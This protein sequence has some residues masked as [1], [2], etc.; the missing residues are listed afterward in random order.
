MKLVIF[1]CLCLSGISQSALAQNGK[2]YSDIQRYSLTFKMPVGFEEVP[3]IANNDVAYEYAIRDKAGSFEARYVIWPVDTTA[4]TMNVFG[5]NPN[6]VFS[7]M[8]QGMIGDISGGQD[9]KAVPFESSEARRDFN[10]HASATALVNVNSGFGKGYSYCRITAIH[11]DNIADAFIFYL[12]NDRS[13][14]QNIMNRTDVY[15]A[16]KFK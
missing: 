11:R 8:L 15:H 10:A 5:V 16:L 3:V 2:F 6:T 13:E 1:A 4:R 12:F 14:L 9:D 7:G